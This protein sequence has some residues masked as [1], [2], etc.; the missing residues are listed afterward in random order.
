MEEIFRPILRCPEYFISNSGLIKNSKTGTILKSYL[1]RHGFCIVGVIYNGKSIS[2]YPHREVA[3]T[4]IENIE[5]RRFVIHKDSNKLNNDASNLKW[6]GSVIKNEQIIKNLPGEVWKDLHEFGNIYEVSTLGRIYSKHT[7]KI[8]VPDI[9]PN[10][11]ESVSLR[12]S[13]LPSKFKTFRLHRLIAK[14]FIENSSN[15]PVV[16]HINAIRSDNRVE[17][18]EWV[19]TQENVNHTKKIGNTLNYK[20]KVALKIIENLPKDR[21]LILISDLKCYLED[22]IRIA[23]KEKNVLYTE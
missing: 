16:N 15:K 14:T 9:D 22:K 12:V 13:K 19:T 6:S 1:D 8:L 3:E 5:K 18:L 10:G 11:Y 17:N 23:K 2:L 21:D 7:E 4:F 20:E